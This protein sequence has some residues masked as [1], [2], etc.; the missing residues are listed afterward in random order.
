MNTRT[1]HATAAKICVSLVLG[2]GVWLRST[3]GSTATE[4]PPPTVPQP[5]LTEFTFFGAVERFV[6]NERLLEVTTIQPYPPQGKVLTY[7][8]RLDPSAKV[9]EV[10]YVWKAKKLVSFRFKLLRWDTPKLRQGAL[11]RVKGLQQRDP[12]TRDGTFVA[13]LIAIDNF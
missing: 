3:G 2:I 12:E 7:R 5:T 9:Y 1:R 8:L 11:V 4:S 10:N 13:L 6:P